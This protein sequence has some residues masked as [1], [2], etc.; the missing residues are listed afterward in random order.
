MF[1]RGCHMVGD[2]INPV[3][4]CLNFV[5]HCFELPSAAVSIPTLHPIF[6]LFFYSTINRAQGTFSWMYS[7]WRDFVK[8]IRC[9]NI[10]GTITIVISIVA[11]YYPATVQILLTNSIPIIEIWIEI[12]LLHKLTKLCTPILDSNGA[13]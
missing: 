6:L 12:I 8:N 13:A 1:P 2:V 4:M 5:C 3:K 7:L 10:K 11:W 9:Y